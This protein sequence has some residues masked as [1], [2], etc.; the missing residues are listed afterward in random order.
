MPPQLHVED[1]YRDYAHVVLRRARSILGD[2]SAAQESVQE[3]FLSLL[4][5]PEQFSGQSSITT[6]LYSA[7]THHCLNSLR[8]QRKRTALLEQE[9]KGRSEEGGVRPDEGLLAS[10]LLANLPPPLATVAIHYYLDEMSQD[11]IAEILGCSRRMVGKHLA[12]LKTAM[13]ARAS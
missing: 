2:E 1:I 11:E 6:F 13:Q 12:K 5:K 3:V 10:E 4:D 8:N 9:G 7:T